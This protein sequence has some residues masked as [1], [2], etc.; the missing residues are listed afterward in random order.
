MVLLAALHSPAGTFQEAAAAR[1]SMSRA[2]APPSRTYWCESR[3][4]ATLAI[5]ERRLTCG[6]MVM[7]ASPSRLGRSGVDRLA[8]LL[9]GA[10]AAYVGDGAVDVGVARL[11]VGLQ[12]AG[13]RHDHAAL[14][15]AALRH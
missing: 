5:R 15:I 2:A 13:D 6:D 4:P 9:I 12:E 10:A 11:R 3:I 14:A 8:H 7:A 1:T